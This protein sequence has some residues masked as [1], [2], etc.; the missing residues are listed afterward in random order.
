MFESLIIN[1]FW[2]LALLSHFNDRDIMQ[3]DHDNIIVQVTCTITKNKPKK[4][5]DYTSSNGAMLWQL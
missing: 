4:T 2:S 1:N 3:N 5:N